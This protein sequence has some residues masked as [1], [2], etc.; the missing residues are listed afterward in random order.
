MTNAPDI[1]KT[2]IIYAVIV[3]LALFVG[4]MLSN[5]LDTS[6]FIE[7]GFVVVVLLFPLLLKWHHPLLI[8]S[9][10]LSAYLFFLPGQPD[11]WLVMAGFSLVITVMQRATGGVKYLISVPQ[12]TWSLV[13]MIAVVVFTAKMTGMGLR[14]A[15]S[16]VYGGKKYVYLLGAI[17]GYFALSSRR[18]PPERA[19]LYIALFF[20]PG[21]M[22]FLGDLWRYLPDSFRY[23]YG[24]FHARQSVIYE[25]V[26]C[27]HAIRFYGAMIVA[28]TVFSYM[29]ARYGIRGIF[30]SGKPWRW[31]LLI[32]V[33]FYGLLGG[34]RSDVIFIALMFGVQFYIEGLHRTKLL[35]IFAVIGLVMAVALVPLAPHL[36]YTAQRALSFLPLN[37]D[38]IARLDA[39]DSAQ[40]RLDMWKAV[41]P[42]VPKHLMLGRGY[43]FSS[44]DFQLLAGYDAAI[45]F[46]NNFDENQIMALSGTYHSGP[47][48]VILIFGIWG[49]IALVWFWGAGIWVLYNN[50]RYG[51][52]L[53]RTV[54]TFLLSI[55]LARIVFYL[56]IF[57]DFGTDMFYF[58][59][60]LGLGVSLNGGVCQPA[61]API[62]ATEKYQAFV[63][64]RPHLQPTLRR[65]GI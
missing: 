44:N 63:G 59:G 31:M 23:I 48:T 21:L 41:L 22:E 55:F 2:L 7:S 34:F 14:T 28:I 37:I 64:V 50:Y 27:E 11:F 39:E 18:I 62:R 26:C 33:S 36:P 1:L 17:M 15:G 51:D 6:T 16:D 54:N 8:V 19:N 30:L 29:Q 43:A 40:W 52:P 38:P 46:N 49:L 60:L 65:P 58:C 45:H 56:F 53:L 12:V 5:P 9:W 3:P 24:F 42:Q 57:G 4:Y 47:L 35:P 13:F 61:P 20:L 25:G 32:I 10:N